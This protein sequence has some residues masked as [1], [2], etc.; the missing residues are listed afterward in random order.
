MLTHLQLPDYEG[1]SRTVSEIVV[2]AFLRK[3]D[4][5]VCMASGHS[6]ARACDLLVEA[7]QGKDL[8]GLQIIGLDEWWGMEP[9]NEGSCRH[10][11]DT[12]LTGPLNLRP[13]QCHFFDGLAKDYAAEVQRMDA[14]IAARGIDLAIVGIGMN[15]HIGF[16]EPGTPFEAGC[17][18]AVLDDVTRSVG[19]KYFNAQTELEKGI[20][21]GLG[22]LM[23]AEHLV[24]IANGAHKADLIKRA[25]EGPVGPAFPASIIQL[26]HR[27]TVVTDVQAGAELSRS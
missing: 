24:L 14:L 3:P 26:H 7:L 6:P 15:G 22:H 20:T 21:I 16:N 2:E 11:F 8:S 25:M 19:Q 23:R 4:L 12:R 1:L 10:F 27:A 13:D 17:H 18:L 9:D 5:M